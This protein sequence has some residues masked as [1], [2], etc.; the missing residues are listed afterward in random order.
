MF[1]MRKGIFMRQLI[2]PSGSQTA[3]YSYAFPSDTFNY[4]YSFIVMRNGVTI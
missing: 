1:L 2:Y 4:S 3:F